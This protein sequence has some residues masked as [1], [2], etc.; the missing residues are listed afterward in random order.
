MS[1]IISTLQPQDGNNLHLRTTPDRLLR[2]RRTLHLILR[3]ADME[4][5]LLTLNTRSPDTIRNQE[6]I[7]DMLDTLTG[8]TLDTEATNKDLSNSSRS[9]LSPTVVGATTINRRK[10]GTCPE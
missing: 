10:V 8:L 3:A 6:L 4:T 1:R 9:T 2:T 7:Q 5:L